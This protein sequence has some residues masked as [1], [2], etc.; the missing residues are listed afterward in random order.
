MGIDDLER[1]T[2][3]RAGGAEQGDLPHSSQS[4]DDPAPYAAQCGPHRDAATTSPELRR[5]RTHPARVSRLGSDRVQREQA[6]E[7][8][9]TGDQQAVDPVEHAAVAAEQP[10][11]VLDPDVPLDERLQ[12]VAD[13]GRDDD[14][15][16]RGRATPRSRR[17]PPCR[18]RRS[19]CKMP[20]A[21]PPTK[22]S[23]L[24][25]GEIGGR[26]P[27]RPTRRPTTYAAVSVANTVMSTVKMASGRARRSRAGA[28]DG[29]R[30]RPIHTVPS[31]V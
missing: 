20:A 15:R 13:D 11:R 16:R 6:V 27:W 1:L 28:R 4:T 7:R 19:S 31:A 9:G 5:C 22:P 14:R 25:P 2:A 24:L 3:D 10:A 8:G 21:A 30:P 29:P 23:Q 18:A 17:T 12:Q 26:H